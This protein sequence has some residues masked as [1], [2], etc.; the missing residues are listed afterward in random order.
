M[1]DRLYFEDFT[2]GRAFDL[3][4]YA[5]SKDEVISFAREFDPQLFHLD[6]AA[7]KASILGG[8]CASGWHNCAM[9]MRMMC[10]AYL[11]NAASLGSSGLSEVKWL[12]PVYVGETLVG[13]M[14]VLSARV[15]ARR[16]EMGIVECRWDLFNERGEKKVE[17]TGVHFIGVKPQC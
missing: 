4:P 12:R 11:N 14:T 7:A 9:L 13:R 1:A 3:G 17:E 5:V 10:D 6:E 16:P 2:V 15:S 8:L